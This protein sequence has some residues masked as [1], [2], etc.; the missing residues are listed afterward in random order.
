MSPL[1]A[2]ARI[3]FCPAPAGR[4]LLGADTMTLATTTTTTIT[5]GSG[6]ESVRE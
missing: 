3:V 6:W 1:S 5:T 4:M 2:P